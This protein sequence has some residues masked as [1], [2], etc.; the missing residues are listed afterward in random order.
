[1]SERLQGKV[2]VVTGS[3]SGIGAA[4]ARA[5]AAEGACVVVSGRRENEGEAVAQAIRAAGGKA[6]FQKTDV[7]SQ[8]ECQALCR[9][10]QEEWGRLD[11]LVNNAGIFP[12]RNLDEVDA[13]FWDQVF[14]INVRGAFFC[15]QAA[16]EFMRPQQS[17]SII[18]IGS[19]NAFGIT[20]PRLVTYGCS[21]TALYGL[22]VNLARVF[23]PD[24]IRVNW[25]TVGWVLT[26]KEFEVQAG[27][28]NDREKML[29]QAAHLPM[30]EY[31][32]EEDI[33]RSCVFLASDEAKHVTGANLNTG[34]G[35]G[36][37]L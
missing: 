5:L 35:L 2:A 30:G 24:H 20:R 27:E 10:A 18:N 8:D 23:A 32:T 14:N 28:G 21:K 9:R 25:V 16:A 33:A 11:V 31:T 34:A 22:T 7:T 3:T 4:I 1:M 13:A 12:R 6:L 15:C 29:S 19:V 26:E 17:G 37:M 36:V